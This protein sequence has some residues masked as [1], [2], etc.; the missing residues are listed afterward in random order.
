MEWTGQSMSS[1][2]VIADDRWATIAVEASVSRGYHNETTL[3]R[4]GS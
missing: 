1:L 4:D 3:G 2:L